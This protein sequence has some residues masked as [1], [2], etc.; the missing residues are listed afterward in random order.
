MW[1]WFTS[2]DQ[3]AALRTCGV[4]RQDTWIFWYLKYWIHCEELQTINPIHFQYLLLLQSTVLGI[5]WSLIFFIFGGWAITTRLCPHPLR[6]KRRR[7]E[8]GFIR[9]K[10]GSCCELAN[11]CSRRLSVLSE[12]HDNSS[13]REKIK[14]QT[15]V[16]L[17]FRQ[18]EVLC[19]LQGHLKYDWLKHFQIDFFQTLIQA[20]VYMRWRTANTSLCVRDEFVIILFRLFDI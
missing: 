1:S 8:P 12:L 19:F 5:S 14:T 16:C 15:F 11:H 9:G 3:K 13:L 2:L 7:L 17:A 10:T 6:R 20:D 18:L 4:P